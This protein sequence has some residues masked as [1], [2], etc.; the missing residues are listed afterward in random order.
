MSGQS[1]LRD[2]FGAVQDVD[3]R[4]RE[5]L[6][7]IPWE[8]LD[9]YRTDFARGCFDDYLNARLPVM[10]YQHMKHEPIGRVR[11]WNKGA[12]ANHFVARFSDFD[13][14]PRARQ[15]F[16]QIRDGDLTDFSFYYDQATAIP[17][18]NTRGAIRFTKAR[19]PEISPVTVGAIP[20]AKATGVRMDFDELHV[21]YPW[22]QVV[23]QRHHRAHVD[24]M[25]IEVRAALAK[26]S[27]IGRIGPLPTDAGLR[28]RAATLPPRPMTAEERS[29]RDRLRAE[30][31]W[32]DRTPPDWMPPMYVEPPSYVPP[33]PDPAAPPAED[34]ALIA[35]EA[36]ERGENPAVALRAADANWRA[37]YGALY[38]GAVP[39]DN[40][41]DWRGERPYPP[42]D[43]IE[44]AAAAAVERGDNP[45]TAVAEAVRSWR[46]ARGFETEQT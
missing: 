34:L 9:S 24:E 14:V 8:V 5:V 1:G 36:T 46:V 39:H 29:R 45:A 44:V 25:D 3:E 30:L 40:T 37:T 10:C 15:A 28:A 4:Q 31:D 43:L 32:A 16:V 42:P 2:A 12:R 26:L 35:Q 38:G 13:A 11:E 23:E 33:R 20:G 22:D 19:M 7:E 17:H 21:G 27:G 41:P 6:V 18:P